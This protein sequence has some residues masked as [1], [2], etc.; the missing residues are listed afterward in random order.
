M[1]RYAPI[2]LFCVVSCHGDRKSND[3]L[4]QYASALE[5]KNY[6]QAYG[7]MDNDF[8]EHHSFESFVSALEESPDS[9]SEVATE[10]RSA[11]KKEYR[12]AM[13][14]LGGDSIPMIFE[15]GAWRIEG[16]PMDFYD[17]SSPRASLRAFVMASEMK[18]WDMLLLLSPESYRDKMTE[19]DIKSHF[20]G[21]DKESINK[22][23]AELKRG[24]QNDINDYGD[25]AEMHYGDER[26]C[27]FVKEGANW[28]I[29]DPD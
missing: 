23:I 3:V 28:K 27:R 25:K 16:N 11:Q 15:D 13:S 8:R 12:A 18:R 10:I 9:P 2:V 6:K 22:M 26:V 7:L 4:E 24:I 19:S 14:L 17:H 20:E 29:L 21:V 1:I 5:S